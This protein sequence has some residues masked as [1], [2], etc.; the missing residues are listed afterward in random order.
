MITQVA[1]DALRST[2]TRWKRIEASSSL[3]LVT[4]KYLGVHNEYKEQA[5][6]DETR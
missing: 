6:F 2:E 5:E 1:G 4:M 3:N